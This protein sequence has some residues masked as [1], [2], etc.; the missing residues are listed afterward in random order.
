MQDELIDM[1]EV[2]DVPDEDDEDDG[3]PGGVSVQSGAA[4]PWFPF[5]PPGL[6]ARL[7]PFLAPLRPVLARVPAP[8]LTGI[9][10]GLGVVVLVL[11]VSAIT[12]RSAGGTRPVQAQESVGVDVVES[13]PTTKPPTPTPRGPTPTP[14]PVV[15]EALPTGGWIGRGFTGPSRIEMMRPAQMLL[16]DNTQ[17]SY[18][19][20]TRFLVLTASGPGAPQWGV[21]LSYVDQTNYVVLQGSTDEDRMPIFNLVWAKDGNGGTIGDAVHVPETPYWGRD[22][23]ELRVSGNKERIRA[24]VDNMSIGQW[25]NKDHQLPGGKKGLFIWFAARMRFDSFVIE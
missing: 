16:F 15:W 4:G 7:A 23:H 3:V 2:P 14:T 13:L 9:G 1:P 18:T 22:V 8:I 17:D 10:S 5:L 11:L 20:V 12:G 6:A 25:T 21:L 24:W 19:I